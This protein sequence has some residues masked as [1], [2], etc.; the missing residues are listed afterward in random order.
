MDPLKDITLEAAGGGLVGLGTLWIL[1]R[2]WVVQS[3]AD[4]T[5]IEAAHA[6]S[7]VILLLRDE[8][9]RLSAS[10]KEY[11]EAL[12]ENLVEMGCLQAEL[13]SLRITVNN[14]SG[15]VGTIAQRKT[16]TLNWDPVNERRASRISTKRQPKTP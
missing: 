2:R 5:A 10:N 7:D 13:S 14:M 12:N 16:D 15:V 9:H 11:I 4:G 3:A 1:I 8:I 6:K